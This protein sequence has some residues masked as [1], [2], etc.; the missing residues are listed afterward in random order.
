MFYCIAIAI[1]SYCKSD[2]YCSYRSDNYNSV[3]I[4]APISN[5]NISMYCHVASCICKKNC[6]SKSANASVILI[7]ITRFN[8]KT[9]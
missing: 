2:V 4:Y 6:S 3:S 8:S 9:A 5:F 1:A 7:K